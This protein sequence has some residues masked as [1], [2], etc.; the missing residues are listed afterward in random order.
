MC[1]LCI[2]TATLIV[3]GSTSAGGLAAAVLRRL[4]HTKAAAPSRWRVMLCIKVWQSRTAA[5]RSVQQW[6]FKKFAMNSDGL[7]P[8]GN[9]ISSIHPRTLR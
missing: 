3:S 5:E 8:S 7:L 1:P 9:G 4:A 2:G 6:K